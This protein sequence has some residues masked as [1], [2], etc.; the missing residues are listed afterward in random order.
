M[1]SVESGPE[2]P[3]GR[4][5]EDRVGRV[6]AGWPQAAGRQ[7]RPYI[8]YA[9]DGPHVTSAVGRLTMGEH[10]VAYSVSYVKVTPPGVDRGPFGQFRRLARGN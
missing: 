8:A 7:P 9:S 5:Q 2:G 6:G 4:V 10:S 1:V 3:E